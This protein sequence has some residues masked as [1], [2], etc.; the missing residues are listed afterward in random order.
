[1]PDTTDTAFKIHTAGGL[2]GI[3]LEEPGPGRAVTRMT[4][5]EDMLNQYQS[6]HGG[7]LFTL[8]DSAF[9]Y[10]CNSAA[11]I[12]VAIEA[13][14]AFRQAPTVGDLLTAV[15]EERSRSRRTGVYDVTVSNQHGDIVALFRGTSYRAKVVDSPEGP[16]S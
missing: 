3:S 6:L 9:G 14:I 1:M 10:A 2:L 4:V 15:C 8:A 11:P 5:R 12:S 16:T 7:F 13:T